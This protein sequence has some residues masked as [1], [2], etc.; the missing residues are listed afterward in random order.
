[1]K[2]IGVAV[3]M[4]MGLGQVFGNE[5]PQKA[6]TGGL[7]SIRLTGSAACSLESLVPKVK[8]LS[9]RY[10]PRIE[11][12]PEAIDGQAFT[13]V[14]WRST[15]N[16]RIE[17]TRSGYLYA[18]QMYE[19]TRT[20]SGLDWERIQE[21][22][23][24]AYLVPGVYRAWVEKGQVVELSGYELSVVAH[25]IVRKEMAGGRQDAPARGPLENS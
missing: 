2:W 11:S 18:L 16:Y 6:R 14:P 9:G 4:M 10:Q 23:K 20:R 22:A 3:V 7:C 8:R 13:R 24:G 12:V 25:K 1:M 5:R 21:E 19:G 17:V 15:A